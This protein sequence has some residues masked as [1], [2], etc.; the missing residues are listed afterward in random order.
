MIQLNVDD[1]KKITR[2]QSPISLFEDFEKNPEY[3]NSLW[4]ILNKNCDM[5]HNEDE[6]RYFSNNLFLAPL[7][8][9]RSTLKKGTLGKILHSR[10]TQSI[11]KFLVNEYK[12][13]LTQKAKKESPRQKEESD[14]SYEQRIATRIVQPAIKEL[15][16]L[17]DSS[18]QEEPQI[19]DLIESLERQA[20]RPIRFDL[21]NFKNTNAW[22]NILRKAEEIDQQK[23]V[24]SDKIILKSNAAKNQLSTLT[25]NQRDSQGIFYYEPNINISSKNHDLSYL[26]QLEDMITLKISPD[27]QTSGGLV[28]L[29]I[30]KR[31]VS[32]TSNFSDRLLNIMGN[33]F[34]KIGTPDV[35]ADKILLL[36]KEVYPDEFFLSEKEFSEYNNERR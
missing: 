11:S 2:H 4:A 22:G 19:Q 7:Q 9:L 1:F 14:K 16:N 23:K 13:H 6:P 8:G 34:S 3:A 27:M 33:Y 12:K 32:L 15:N 21:K 31:K 24:Q 25:L 26:I 20:P 30:G 36:Y 10:Q 5:V 18:S 29:L 17:I 28:N 35:M